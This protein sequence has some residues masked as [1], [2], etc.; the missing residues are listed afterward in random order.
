MRCDKSPKH[1]GRD[2][3][4]FRLV[5]LIAFMNLHNNFSVAGFNDAASKLA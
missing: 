2:F 4:L 3:Q 1:S 5:Y